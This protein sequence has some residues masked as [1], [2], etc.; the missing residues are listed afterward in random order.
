MTT[1][2]NNISDAKKGAIKL[3]MR[4]P[5]NDCG[6]HNSVAHRIIC[7]KKIYPVRESNF[8]ATESVEPEKF[9]LLEQIKF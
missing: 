9:D 3:K 7:Q 2:C 1:V 6:N 8:L 5:N 4:V